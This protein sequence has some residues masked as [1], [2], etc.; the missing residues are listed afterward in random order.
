M[1]EKFGDQKHG[2][3]GDHLYLKSVS[4]EEY[5]FLVI[6]NIATHRNNIFFAIIII[7]FDVETVNLC[8]T[9]VIEKKAIE[10]FDET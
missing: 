7:N 10:K 9:N 1:L 2:F 8:K 3:F 5:L 4:N 6:K